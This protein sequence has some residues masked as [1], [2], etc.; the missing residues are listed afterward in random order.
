MLNSDG[1]TFDFHDTHLLKPFKFETR[2]SDI[3]GGLPVL[4]TARA[5]P[6]LDRGHHILSKCNEAVFRAHVFLKA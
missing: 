3:A 5:Q 6:A 1:Y 4:M 2:L